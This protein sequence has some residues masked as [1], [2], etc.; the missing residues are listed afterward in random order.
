PG[1]RTA[2]MI[3]GFAT[4]EDANIT[5]NAG[6][7]VEGKK[8]W[9]RKQTQEP[10]RCLKSQCFSM[11]KALHCSATHETCGQYEFVEDVIHHC[12][13]SSQTV[14]EAEEQ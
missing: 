7:F 13:E 9:G 6:L 14:G 2:I 3:L 10:R 5:I 11:H 8:V 12:L 4:R 1:Q